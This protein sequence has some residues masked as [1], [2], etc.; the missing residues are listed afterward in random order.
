MKTETVSYHWLAGLALAATL[1]AQARQ[2]VPTP[3][4]RDHIAFDARSGILSLDLAD[5]PLTNV[6]RTLDERYGLHVL[7]TDRTE[8]HVTVTV[9]LPFADAMQALLGEQAYSLEVR[10]RDLE[11]APP[12]ASGK[13]AASSPDL[14]K[15][16]IGPTDAPARAAD[17]ALTNLEK[18]TPVPT[19]RH[20]S[21]EA[22]MAPDAARL[23][24]AVT[25]TGQKHARLELHVSR[26]GA[27][28]V[29]ILVEVDG[30]LVQNDFRS[31][32]FLFVI[33]DAEA[34][35][36]LG[37]MVDPFAVRPFHDGSPRDP[38]RMRM[39]LQPPDDVTIWLPLPE[40]F[41]QREVLA[42]THIELRRVIRGDDAPARLEQDALPALRATSEL[43]GSVGPTS[44]APVM[45]ERR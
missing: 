42:R 9:R 14:S 17:P 45:I 44:L 16:A 13:P 43:A 28:R 35:P 38:R 8:R 5:V 7:P 22:L 1:A 24:P 4:V 19:V 6:L 31:G 12:T 30:P 10:G 41:L 40:R 34:A 32:P 29:G 37:A 21:L 20:E 15:P 26:T 25:A 33:A 27:V 36:V 2:V 3:P 39:R 18:L 23:P 11:L